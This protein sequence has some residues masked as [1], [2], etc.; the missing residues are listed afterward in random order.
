[1]SARY[2]GKTAWIRV[3]VRSRKEKGR[4]EKGGGMTAK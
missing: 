2:A 4:N 3:V 1:M